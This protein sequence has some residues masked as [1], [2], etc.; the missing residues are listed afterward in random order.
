VQYLSWRLARYAKQ[1]RLPEVDE[2]EDKPAEQDNG[3]LTATAR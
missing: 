3:S 2:A 1:A